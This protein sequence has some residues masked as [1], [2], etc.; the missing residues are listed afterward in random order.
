MTFDEDSNFNLKDEIKDQC[1]IDKK[2]SV[3]NE[4]LKQPLIPPALALKLRIINNSYHRFN[5][6]V[7]KIVHQESKRYL[8]ILIKNNKL[9][10]KSKIMTTISKF[11]VGLVISLMLM[12]CQF[13]SNFGFGVRGNGDVETIERQ[14]KR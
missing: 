1:K 12:S 6:S 4:V 13:N 10:K 14:I 5:S 11:I 9:I 7:N 8:H 2:D 3:R